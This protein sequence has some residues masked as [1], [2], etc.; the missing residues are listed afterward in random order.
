MS[1]QVN[2][3]TASVYL[4]QFTKIEEG[5]EAAYKETPYEQEGSA[6]FKGK[7][8]L[9]EA[10]Q[11]QFGKLRDTFDGFVTFVEGERKAGK[12]ID[13]K[14]DEKIEATKDMIQKIVGFKIWGAPPSHKLKELVRVMKDALVEYEKIYVPRSEGQMWDDM[15]RDVNPTREEMDHLY[16]TK[17]KLIDLGKECNLAIGG[18]YGMELSINELKYLLK[19]LETGDR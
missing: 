12:K 15:R 6:Q 17:R 16:E 9:D 2:I 13:K 10:T 19:F 1:G 4:A 7:V 5:L 8:K 14:L 11:K 18:A 3:S